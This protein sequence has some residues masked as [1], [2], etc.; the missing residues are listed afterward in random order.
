EVAR[1][2]AG[3]IVDQHVDAAEPL[4]RGPHRRLGIGA[5]G[6]VELDGHEILRAAQGAGHAPAVPTRGHDCVAGR[7]GGLGDLDAHAAARSSDE[8]D[9]PVAHDISFAWPSD[10]WFRISTLA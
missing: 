4:D 1:V 8:P 10:T 6:D 2:E 9:R 3:G 5:A 7:Q